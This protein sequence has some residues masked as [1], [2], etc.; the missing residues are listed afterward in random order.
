MRKLTAIVMASTLA[1]S[2]VNMAHAADATATAAPEKPALHA[3]GKKGHEFNRGMM[4]L[5][6]IDLTDAQKQQ[7]KQI[8]QNQ[9]S[10]VQ[11]PSQDDMRAAHA[12]IAS[13]NFDR[14]KAETLIDQEAAANKARML[15]QMEAQNKIYNVLTAEQQKQ[16]NANFEKHLTEGPKHQGKMQTSAK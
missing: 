8:M 15:A 3:K 16:Y 1:L 2:A 6:G 4:M 7:I 9:R 10:Q 13:G 11:R 12:I 14:S 5:K